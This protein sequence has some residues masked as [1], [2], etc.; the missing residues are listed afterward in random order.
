MNEPRKKHLV[1]VAFGTEEVV[2]NGQ[3]RADHDRARAIALELGQ[4][5]LHVYIYPVT[6]GV[7]GRAI[8][9]YYDGVLQTTL[10]T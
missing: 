8:R 2:V 1:V 6:A 9:Y 7:R 4:K 10:P 3:G 5:A